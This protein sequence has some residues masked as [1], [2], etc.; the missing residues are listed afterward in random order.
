MLDVPE[1]RID[2]AHQ[3]DFAIGDLL[4]LPSTR[5]LVRGEERVIIE[6][7]VM[8]VL[9]ALH[10][11]AGAVVS[12][13]DLALS[14]WEGR[15]VGEDAINR[16][17]SRLRKLTDGIAAGAFRVETVTRVGYRMIEEGQSG[18][19]VRSLDPTPISESPF[20]RRAILAGAGALLTVGGIAYWTWSTPGE[21][22]PSQAVEL[23]EVAGNAL[24]YGTP[25]QVAGGIG[26]LQQAT[27]EA[28]RWAVPWGM[29]ALAYG[30]QAQ[31]SPAKDREL[32]MSRARSA[33]QRALELDPANEDARVAGLLQ[34]G[35][36]RRMSALDADQGTLLR[37]LPD[38]F[39]LN[40]ARASFLTDVGRL[41]DA[42]GHFEKAMSLDASSPQL[43][44]ALANALSAVGRLDEADAAID[45]AF[46]RWPRH[47]GVWFSRYK[48]LAF[49]G[50]TREA[51]AMIE[52]E[53]GRPIGVPQSNFDLC[54]IE[55]RALASRSADDIDAA[56]SAHRNA[57]RVGVGFAQNAILFASAVN[58][59]DEAFAMAAAYYFGQGFRIG[60]QRYSREQGLFTP[61]QRRHTYFLFTPPLAA[62]RGDQRFL[63]ITRG[64]GLEDYWRETGTQPDYRL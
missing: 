46:E 4:V 30:Q 19:S 24:R 60:E 41:R 64:T 50:R 8:Q 20:T 22:P 42:I 44:F 55:S 27:E 31:Q 11:A 51:M 29:L 5:E 3:A 10:R 36:S 26:M 56:I 17:I 63:T 53:S 48:L 59:L 40:M 39:V 38:H 12:K 54:M 16:V 57:A 14:C 34:K 23:V 13:D 43:G 32:L 18:R 61:P 45:R 35:G 33:G 58:R 15:V 47:Y 1:T 7:R 28:P 6:P 9:V 49:T 25:E 37:A 2:L 21:A 52:N 62:M